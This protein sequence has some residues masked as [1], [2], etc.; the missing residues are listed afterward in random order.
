LEQLR[1]LEHGD[2]IEI[3]VA[4]SIPP[5]GVDTLEDL[6]AA[7]AYAAQHQL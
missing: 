4:E 6:E 7:V 3:A 5:S 2:A 1:A